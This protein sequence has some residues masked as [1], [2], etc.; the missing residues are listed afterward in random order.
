MRDL[1]AMFND[2]GCTNVRTYIQS[3]NVVFCAAPATAKRVAAIV[4]QQ[5]N[6][7]F[8]FR[9]PVVIRTAGDLEKVAAGNPFHKPDPDANALHVGFLAETPDKRQIAALDPNRSPGDVFK[10]QG[11]EIYLCLPNGVAKSKLTNS[12]LDA[13]L[14]TT[15]TIRNWRTVMKLLEMTRVPQ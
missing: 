15:S 5:I 1:A 2:A 11:R 9:I 3:G 13:T 7:R 6:A 8:G 4:S 14:S 12:Y 10:V